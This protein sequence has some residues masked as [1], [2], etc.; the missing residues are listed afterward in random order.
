M[1]TFNDAKQFRIRVFIRDSEG[2]RGFI[3]P[4]FRSDASLHRAIHLYYR[5]FPRELYIILWYFASFFVFFDLFIML[6]PDP[7]TL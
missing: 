2:S 3:V 4:F 6:N 7:I 1:T 5:I